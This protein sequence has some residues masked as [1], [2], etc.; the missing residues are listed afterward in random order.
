MAIV[1]RTVLVPLAGNIDVNLA[2]FDRFAGRG[3]RVAVRVAGAAA[4]VATKTFTVLVGSDILADEAQVSA[5]LTIGA[6]P[7]S[8]Q[9]PV[10][11]FG[12]PADPITIRLFNS[13]AGAESVT[14]E[15]DIQNA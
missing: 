3:G 9:P 5:E 6:G 4:V 1:R 11:G 2:P 8:R 7:D 10:V 13:A 15:A 14:V 12:A